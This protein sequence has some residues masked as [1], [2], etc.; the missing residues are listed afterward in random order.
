MQNNLVSAT[1]TQLCVWRGGKGAEGEGDPSTPKTTAFLS[2]RRA[3]S[4]LKF[5]NETYT[6][7]F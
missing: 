2:Y 3:T 1:I 6:V 5:Q 7:N 4:L